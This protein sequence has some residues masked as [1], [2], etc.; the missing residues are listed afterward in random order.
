MTVLMTVFFKKS[1]TSSNYHH[2]IANI[3]SSPAS[4]SP[5]LDSIGH[6]VVPQIVSKYAAD[7]SVGDRFFA[8]QLFSVIISV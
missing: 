1:P 8:I 5:T 4:L 7:K 2:K 6:R 3:T